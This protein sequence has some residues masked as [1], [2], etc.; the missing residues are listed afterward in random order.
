[1]LLSDP[2]F[3]PFRK[4]LTESGVDVENVLLAG[5]IEYAE[6]IVP[7]KDGMSIGVLLLP[8]GR[9]VEFE[10][11][12]YGAP[13]RDAFRWEEISLTDGLRRWPALHAAIDLF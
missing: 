9:V 2:L 1:M 5:Q 3:G 11:D 7:D 10:G 4:W 8:E 13:G 6:G 12:I